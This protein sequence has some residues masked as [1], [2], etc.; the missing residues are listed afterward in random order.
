MVMYPIVG[1]VMDEWTTDGNGF[2]QRYVGVFKRALILVLTTGQKIGLE[3]RIR[4]S[5]YTRGTR[6]PHYV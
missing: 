5:I 4:W 1:R 6:S 3:Y 2:T